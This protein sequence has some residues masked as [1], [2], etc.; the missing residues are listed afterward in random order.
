MDRKSETLKAQNSRGFRKKTQV[1]HRYKDN[2]DLFSIYNILNTL[3]REEQ[4]TFAWMKH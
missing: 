3:Q 1:R 4:A 2:G